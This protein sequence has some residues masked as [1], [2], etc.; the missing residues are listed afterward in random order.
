MKLSFAPSTDPLPAWLKTSTGGTTCFSQRASRSFAKPT[1]VILSDALRQWWIENW[2]WREATWLNFTTMCYKRWIW[3]L[4]WW[5]EDGACTVRFWY[6]CRLK[7]WQAAIQ[8]QRRNP[9]LRLWKW[10][11]TQTVQK[12]VYLLYHGHYYLCLDLVW[13]RYWAVILVSDFWKWLSESSCH[14]H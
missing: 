11:N 7:D 13:E 10:L 2:G 12:N 9:Q 4:R 3:E 14:V 6:Q 8:A 5:R 1:S